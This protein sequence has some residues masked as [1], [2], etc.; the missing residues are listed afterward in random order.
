MFVMKIWRHY[1]C[2][3]QCKIYTDHYIF[4]K[5]E[6]NLRQRRWLELLKKDYDLEIHYHPGKANVVADALSRKAQ[7]S[8]NPTINMQLRCVGGYWAFGCRIDFTWLNTYFAI[9]FRGQSFLLEEIKFHQKEDAKLQRIR[10]NLEKEKSPSL[11][12]YEDGTLRFQN[13]LCVP[14]K[15]ELKEKIL[16]ETHN[17]RYSIHL[18]GTKMYRESK[19]SINDLLGNWDH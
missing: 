11:V 15:V 8:L 16:T 1:L 4:T 3:A 12:V 5:K 13:R 7:H 10:Q 14:D 9:S 17:T 19:L 6:L 2:G 18:G